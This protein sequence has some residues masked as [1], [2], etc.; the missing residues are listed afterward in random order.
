M[1]KERFEQQFKD[2]PYRLSMQKNEEGGYTSF[3]TKMA[4]E[5]WVAATRNAQVEA[6]EAFIALHEK[7]DLE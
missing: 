4:W 2:M 7:L 5:G 6:E 1:S 3:A